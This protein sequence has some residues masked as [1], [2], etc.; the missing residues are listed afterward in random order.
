MLELALREALALGH[1]YIGTEHVLFGLLRE[2]DGVA[3]HILLE[4]DVDDEKAREAVMGFPLR[5]P[6]EGQWRRTRPAARDGPR[7]RAGL[8]RIPD[9]AFACTSY[10]GVELLE[11]LG[12]RGWE[13]V[14]AVP[15]ATGIRA[16]LQTARAIFWIQ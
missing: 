15:S 10:E 11:G 14:G 5:A 6:T 4:F 2:N 8:G 13:L 7:P 16:H 12:E 3:A 9:R 1:N